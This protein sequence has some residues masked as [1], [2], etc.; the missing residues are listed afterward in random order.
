MKTALAIAGLLS[1]L[2]LTGCV[3]VVPLPSADH[4]VYGRVVDRRQTK[5]IIAGQT[6]RAEVVARL[7][8]QFR[9]S[10]RVA[11]LAYAWEQPAADIIWWV[12]FFNAAGGGYVERSHWRAFFVEFDP[13][14]R[15]SRMEFVRLSGHGSLDEQL[16]NWAMR[17]HQGFWETGGG[18]FNPSTG[19]PC[20][21]E[22]MEKSGHAAK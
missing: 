3:A 22:A 2:L 19:V 11:A 8:E 13:A 9:D 21:V 20:F 10:P 17:T 1:A 7:G 16:E 18:I 5:F 4:R 15:V 6:T 14:S 12:V